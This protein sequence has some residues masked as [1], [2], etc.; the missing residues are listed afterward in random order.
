MT[1]RERYRRTFGALHVSPERL[2]EVYSMKKHNNITRIG[3]VVLAAACIMALLTVSAFAA[4]E[5]TGGKVFEKIT[6]VVNNM[7][8]Q[9]TPNGNGG[10]TVRTEDGNQYEYVVKDAHKDA[11]GSTV[12]YEVQVG[13]DVNQMMLQVEGEEFTAEIAP[14]AEV[15]P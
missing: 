8:G 7:I 10:F 15:A 12:T 1:N 13:D 5:V 6:V 2:R 9:I 4:N 14:A 11:D 3:R